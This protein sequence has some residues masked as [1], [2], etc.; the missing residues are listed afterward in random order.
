MRMFRRNH[1]KS[2]IVLC[3]LALA[4]C[5]DHGLLSTTQS[6]T[7][8]EANPEG[9]T[10]WTDTRPEYHLNPG[11][12]IRVQFL[13]TPELAEEAIIAP[14]G[15]LALRA[16]GQ[17]NAQNMTI[18]QLQDAVT[19]ASSKMLNNPVVTVSVVE[20]A[21]ARVFVGG[22]VTKPGAYPIDTSRGALEAI[23]LAGG[24]DRESRADEVVLIRRDPHNKPMLRTVDL[25]GFISNGFST[26]DVPLYAGDIVYV[27]RNRISEIDLWMEQFVTKFVP[28][29]RSFD[30]SITK[31]TGA[32]A[33][34]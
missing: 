13:L 12:R 20:A 26:G 15:T 14:D 33:L 21:G 18:A 30:Y 17:I 7:P 22:S 28:F 4:A 16:A 31:G 9:F 34:F 29:N 2:C 1:L 10:A 6:I 27:P 11:D 19:K 25:R 5:T 24:F 8:T 3:G 32:A 23:V